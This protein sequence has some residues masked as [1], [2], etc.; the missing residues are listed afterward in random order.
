MDT[1]QWEVKE[2]GSGSIV[3]AL[4]DGTMPYVNV[5]SHENVSQEQR[6]ALAA[7]LARM[8]NG[9]VVHITC[10]MGLVRTNACTLRLPCGTQFTAAGGF[11]DADPPKHCW[12]EK[13]DAKSLVARECLTK[14]INL[15]NESLTCLHQDPM[16]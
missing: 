9:D 1:V 7:W 3:V 14:K 15:I 4:S 16:P 13:N 2:H 10:F 6:R 5:V 11:Y 12:V 8:L